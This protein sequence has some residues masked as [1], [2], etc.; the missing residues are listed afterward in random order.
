MLQL[1]AWHELLLPPAMRKHHNLSF[2][3]EDK[4][5]L[6]SVGMFTVTVYAL[7]TL[8]IFLIFSLKCKM[9]IYF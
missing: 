2:S 4:V 9:F 1:E 7:I 8:I 6:T 5:T 3:T